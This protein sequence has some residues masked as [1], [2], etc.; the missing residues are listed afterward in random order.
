MSM[1]FLV[2]LSLICATAFGAVARADTPPSAFVGPGLVATPVL[3]AVA[4]GEAHTCVVRNQIVWCTG[5]NAAGQLGLGTFTRH[6]AFAESL[7]ADVTQVAAGGNTTCATKRDETLWCWG[8]IDTGFNTDGNIIRTN[9]AVPTQ[10]PLSLVK[11]VAVGPY[12]SCALQIDGTAW[13]WGKNRYG[14]L[15]NGTKNDSA[16][17]VAIG[18]HNFIDI[19]VGT[20]HTCAIDTDHAVW[21][22]GVNA[23]HRL[24]LSGNKAKL[25]PT[26]VNKINGLSIATGDAFTCVIT[27]SHKV[28]CFGR[29]NYGQLGTTAGT[30]R[31][32][33]STVSIKNPVALNAG[34]EYACA[35][36][37]AATTWCWGRNRYGQLANG[38][39]VAKWKPQKVITSLPM[40]PISFMATGASHVCGINTTSSAMWCWGLGSSGQLGDSASSNRPRGTIAWQNGVQL[41]S[42]GTDSTARLVV[43]G[44]ISCDEERRVTY[45]VGALGSQCGTEAT[46]TLAELLNPDAVLALGDLQYEGAS[47]SDF[48]QFY[49]PT[50]GR[51]K[52]KTYPVRGNHEYVTNAAAGYVDY[53]GPLSPSYWTTNAG[54]WR[55]IAVDSWCQGLLYAGCSTTSP[56][57][58]W[59]TKQLQRAHEE[60]R[61]SLVV[62]HHPFVSSGPNATPTTQ[63][64]WKAAVDGGADLV[65]T[66]HD[67]HYERFAPLTDTG[68]VATS[69]GTPLIIAGL[70]GAPTYALRETAPGSQA[71]D[72]REHGVVSLTL[73]PLGYTSE[74]VSAVDG[75]RSD[76]Y[77][78]TCTP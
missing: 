30:P 54:S 50:W 55:I 21:C 17:P 52:A 75:L 49:D 22:W 46:A 56:Q 11:H 6:T 48:K 8:S 36:T 24:G 9:V 72:N 42:I 28:Q 76:S 63:Y 45:G 69:G 38:S 51:L 65:M 20:D 64:L 53:F 34:R 40:G 15:G 23:Q 44:D 18:Q 61:C 68:A 27:T 58:V 14:Q 71:T 66:G 35:I 74:F 29:N 77:T 4:A 13:C 12:H 67:H 47:S 16:L 33:P 10:I 7:M 62:M 32:T 26:R 19:A 2:A 41:N 5:A 37:Q 25:F 60:G 31:T 70:G 59:L 57:T 43:T 39:N 1:K 73:T 3:S 78:G